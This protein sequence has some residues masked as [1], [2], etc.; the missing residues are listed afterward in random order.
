MGWCSRRLAPVGAMLAPR[1]A[2]NQGPPAAAWPGA[3]SPGT[4]LCAQPHHTPSVVPPS[5]LPHLT[6]AGTHQVQLADLLLAFDISLIVCKNF[7]PAAAKK[8]GVSDGRNAQVG[9]TAVAGGCSARGSGCQIWGFFKHECFR[10]IWPPQALFVQGPASPR[11]LRRGLDGWPGRGGP[12]CLSSLGKHF[13]GATAHS[14]WL[15]SALAG[16]ALEIPKS[17]H[18]LA[19][20]VH[21]NASW[22]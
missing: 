5:Q 20:T 12:A 17:I 14:P 22:P 11:V 16:K 8:G 6:R 7:K 15:L 18:H 21:L 2:F 1:L 13:P 3:S 10:R 19:R 4:H 9:S